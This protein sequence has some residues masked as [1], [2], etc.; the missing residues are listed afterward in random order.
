M[1]CERR[2]VNTH[3][4][5][6]LYSLCQ[7]DARIYKPSITA[8]PPQ[9]RT[10]T[11]DTGSRAPGM[12]A[13]TT[14]V[15]AAASC[16]ASGLQNGCQLDALARERAKTVVHRLVEASDHRLPTTGQPPLKRQAVVCGQ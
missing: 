10:D 15:A 13:A 3:H 11:F 7:P 4:S 8:D 14:S 2:R 16:I 1:C 12:D 9:S 5:F 6:N